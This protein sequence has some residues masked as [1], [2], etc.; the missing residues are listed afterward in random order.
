VLGEADARCTTRQRNTHNTESREIRYPWYPWFGRAVTVYEV[1]TRCEQTVCRCGLDNERH[2][3]SLE[4]PLWMFESA[5]CSHLHL[6]S[7]PVVDG[8]ALVEVQALLRLA[9]PGDAYVLQARHRSLT[10]A[11]GADVAV[12]TAVTRRRPHRT[13]RAGLLHT[14]PAL[15]E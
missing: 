8:N 15:G 4:V 2:H 11:G 10:S 14:A 3:R 12:G 13:V 6:T 9:A 1:L 5:A 7:T